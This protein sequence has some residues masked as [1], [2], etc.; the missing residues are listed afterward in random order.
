MILLVD[1][2]SLGFT[3]GI[4]GAQS[5]RRR[6]AASISPVDQLLRESCRPAF[7]RE[8]SGLLLSAT[9]KSVRPG[10][11]TAAGGSFVLLDVGLREGIQGNLGVR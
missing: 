4:L 6:R 11:V 5:E 3:G 1:G 9:A 2:H 10:N 7:E 8:Q